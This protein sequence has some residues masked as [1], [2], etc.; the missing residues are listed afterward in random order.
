MGRGKKTKQF[1]TMILKIIKKK[2]ISIYIMMEIRIQIGSQNYIYIYKYVY[3]YIY[4]YMYI[5][6]HIH[7]FTDIYEDCG[8]LWR[9]L[10]EVLSRGLVL[11][12]VDIENKT[13]ITIL[14]IL[15]IIYLYMYL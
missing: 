5:Y 13:Q 11:I 15:Y 8:P 12:F 1:K 3:I 2:I 9:Q 4:L 6:I 7:I 14:Y 10:V